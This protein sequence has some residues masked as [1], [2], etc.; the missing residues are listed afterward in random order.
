MGE[1]LADLGGL[2]LSL[3]A[4]KFRHD[5]ENA[6]PAIRKASIRALFKSW[7]STSVAVQCA[8]ALTPVAI[9][10]AIAMCAHA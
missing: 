7:V 3:G 5:A 8:A 9:T 10:G 2:S 1:N 6:S 4:L